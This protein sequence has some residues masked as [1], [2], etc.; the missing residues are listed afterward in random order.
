[1][2]PINARR[3]FD[4]VLVEHIAPRSKENGRLKVT[5]L[6]F[7]EYGFSR[8]VIGISIDQV[9]VI[10]LIAVERPGKA[11]GPDDAGEPA[12]YR[13][14]CLPTATAPETNEWKRFGDIKS[15]RAAIARIKPAPAHASPF[16]HEGK[17]Q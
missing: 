14:T 1:V 10:G 3:V 13:I 17:Y 12:Q 8:R 7:E 11:A 9:V 5:W 2:L 16:S 4:R 15:A 6:N